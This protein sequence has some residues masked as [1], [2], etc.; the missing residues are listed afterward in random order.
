LNGPIGLVSQTG[1]SW[2]FPNC[3]VEYPFSC[4]ISARGA[5]FSGRADV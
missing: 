2:H 3:A 1:T 4:R 5:V